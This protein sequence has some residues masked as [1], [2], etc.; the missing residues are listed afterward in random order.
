MA[1]KRYEYACDHCNKKFTTGYRRRNAK[2]F[3]SVAC[4]NEGLFEARSSRDEYSAFRIFTHV[5]RKES[6]NPHKTE[7]FD[8][9][10]EFLYDLYHNVQEGKCA[11]TG[12]DM[13]LFPTSEVV[14][15]KKSPYNASLDRIDSA[16]PYCKEN[17]QFVCLGINYAKNTFSQDEIIEFVSDIQENTYSIK[18]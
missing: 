13:I 5:K 4:R 17:V 15:R 18:E 1:K 11:I 8:L 2:K 12:L 10:V 16:K 7:G 6:K 14:K 9:D 3:C